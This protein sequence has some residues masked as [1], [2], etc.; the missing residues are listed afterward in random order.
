MTKEMS[1][2]GS[3]KSVRKRKDPRPES[4]E[5]RIDEKCMKER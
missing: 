1:Q 5:R 3:M 2:C 4:S